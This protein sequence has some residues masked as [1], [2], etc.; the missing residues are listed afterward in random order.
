MVIIAFL[1]A[2]CRHAPQVIT[3]HS[4]TRCLWEW[5]AFVTA[6]AIGRDYQEAFILELRPGRMWV[7][8]PKDANRH[9][10]LLID[11][12]S[13]ECVS[14]AHAWNVQ[15]AMV[16]GADARRLLVVTGTA[17]RDEPYVALIEVT[18]REMLHLETICGEEW[19]VGRTLAVRCAGKILTVLGMDGR[20]YDLSDRTREK[21]SRM[22]LTLRLEA[23]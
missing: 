5:P 13:K 16:V 21:L 12:Q 3:L 20:R 18:D 19:R 14:L 4:K 11:E 9:P 15:S 22:G 8:E 6:R 2:G 17:Y 1:V 10:L 7:V 23:K